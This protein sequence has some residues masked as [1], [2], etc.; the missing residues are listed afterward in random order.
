MVD[1]FTQWIIT[2]PEYYD[3]VSNKMIL[4]RLQ[5]NIKLRQLQAQHYEKALA[6]LATMQKIAPEETG[7]LFEQ[8]Q[9]LARLNQTIAAIE[10][11][12]QFIERAPEHYDRREAKL[13]LQKLNKQL[14]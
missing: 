3:V 13:L 1:A 8:G 10:S 12:K 14:N 5:N 2:K 11:L 6:T 7:F 9:I 4:L